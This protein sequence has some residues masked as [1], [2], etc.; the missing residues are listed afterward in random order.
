MGDGTLTLVKNW[1][2]G[3]S[4]FQAIQQLQGENTQIHT[5]REKSKF[6]FL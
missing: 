3:I 5:P 2:L 1:K 4:K 6:F